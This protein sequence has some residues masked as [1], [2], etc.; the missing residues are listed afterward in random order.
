[1]AGGGNSGSGGGTGVGGAGGGGAAPEV[2]HR[3]A[4]AAA[5]PARAATPERPAPPARAARAAQPGVRHGRRGRNRRW[6]GK[7]RRLGGSGRRG[8][9]RRW[10]RGTRRCRWGRR[11]EANARRVGLGRRDRRRRR[12]HAL[13]DDRGDGVCGAAARRLDH[14]GLSPVGRERRLSRRA[15]STGGGRQEHH[16]RRHADERTDHRRRAGRFPGATKGAAAT[17]SQGGGQGA[18]AGSVTD[19]AISTYH[20]HIVLLM[21]GTND[22]NGNINVSSA[23]TRLG[24]L[25]DEIITDAPAALVVVASIIPIAERRHQRARSDLQRRD[26]G[27]REHA[28]RGRQ[29]RRL[30]RQLRGVHQGYELPRRR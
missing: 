29:T 14:R 26:P 8:R 15:V 19:T 12:V 5:S 22:I 17:P 30:P 13:P 21:I 18:L 16:L 27:P 28:R 23:P 4:L 9:H 6:R 10:G 20:P 25:I 7:R 2:V 3:A 11:R 24:Q 1:M